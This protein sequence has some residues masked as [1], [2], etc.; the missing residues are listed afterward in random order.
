M[1]MVQ[2]L[3]PLKQYGFGVLGVYGEEGNYDIEGLW[4]WKGPNILLQWS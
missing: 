1:G 2:R 3:E 4:L